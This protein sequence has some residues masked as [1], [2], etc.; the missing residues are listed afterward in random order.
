MSI[1]KILQNYFYFKTNSNIL[2]CIK[3]HAMRLTV[4]YMIGFTT[5]I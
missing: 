2:I 1:D 4:F 3:G 5:Y